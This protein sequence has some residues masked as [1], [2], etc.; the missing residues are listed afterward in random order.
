[1]TAKVK[2]SGP[3]HAHD[4][5]PRWTR[6]VLPAVLARAIEG[7]TP[8][9]VRPMTIAVLFASASLLTACAMPIVGNKPG[10]TVQ[11][12][13]DAAKRAGDPGEGGRRTP[14]NDTVLNPYAQPVTQ[15]PHSPNLPGRDNP[16][17]PGGH[18]T[19]D[20]GMGVNP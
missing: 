19:P 4:L 20:T 3:T 16:L 2:A 15:A 1:M 7:S 18:Q 9:T 12:Q 5:Y 11:E 14:T 8:V 17:N 13:T 6:G 10:N